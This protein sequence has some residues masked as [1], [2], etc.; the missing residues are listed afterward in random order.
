MTTLL[1][2][3][4][5]DDDGGVI[6]FPFRLDSQQEDTVIEALKPKV[7]FY[8]QGEG[9]SPWTRYYALLKNGA[10]YVIED[11]DRIWFTI[12]Y[13]AKAKVHKAT[14]VAPTKLGLVHHAPSNMNLDGL[15]AQ[16]LQSRISDLEQ[17]DPPP[18]TL[19]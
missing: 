12:A 9:K 15:R 14:Q 2:R 16:T 8:R 10:L 3:F 4:R 18:L 1:S 17:P 6:T 7:Y 11:Y 19:A 13:D 5:K